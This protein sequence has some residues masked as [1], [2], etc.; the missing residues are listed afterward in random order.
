MKMTG[1]SA[2][3][4][5]IGLLMSVA[6]AQALQQTYVSRTGAGTT[7]SA[8]APCADF[9]T[10]HD[11]TDTGGMIICLDEVTQNGPLTITKTIE[12]DCHATHAS[13]YGPSGGDAITINTAGV[14][15]LLRGLDIRGF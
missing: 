9:Q 1:L 3:L 5:A 10:A 8:A 11:A 12:I 4:A 14:G 2:A 13:I 6:A 15:V 7:C